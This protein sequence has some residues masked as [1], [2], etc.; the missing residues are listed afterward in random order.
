MHRNFIIRRFIVTAVMFVSV[1][2][3]DAAE[4]A[5][6]SYADSLASNYEVAG[7]AAS[8]LRMQ[9]EKR[10]PGPGHGLAGTAFGAQL[11]L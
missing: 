3:L 10:G 6:K 7:A 2:C 1:N 11:Q 8:A 5:A 4:S 9:W